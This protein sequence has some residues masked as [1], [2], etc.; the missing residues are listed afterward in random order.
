[1][2]GKMAIPWK[3]PLKVHCRSLS[4]VL[5]HDAAHYGLGRRGSDTLMNVFMGIISGEDVSVPSFLNDRNQWE[6]EL[7]ASATVCIVAMTINE[8]NV[9]MMVCQCR[10]DSLLCI[11]MGPSTVCI[12]I[13]AISANLCVA[14]S[15][16]HSY[17]I[18]V[19]WP[20]V[21][22]SAGHRGRMHHHGH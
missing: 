8:V 18:C 19:L 15:C 12:M 4:L 9:C 11:A 1:M 17:A 22:I 20:S 2:F 21:P 13:V 10:G 5:M 14:I 16:V 6:P 3:Y 7:L